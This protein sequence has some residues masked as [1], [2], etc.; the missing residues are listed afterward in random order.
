MSREKRYNR[1]SWMLAAFVCVQAAVFLSGCGNKAPKEDTLHLGVMYSSDI[2]PL[3]MMKEKGMDSKYGFRLDMQVFS[4]AKDRDAAL[5][6]GKLDGV[7]TD[8]IGV[9]MYQNANLDVKITGSTDGDYV[10][11][12]GLGTGITSLEDAKG[13]SIAVSENTLIEYSLDYI[14]E[15]KGFTDAYLDKQVVPRIPDRLEMIR[16][17]KID[18]GLL[19]EPFSILAAQSG[20]L[21]LGSANEAG[22]Y[23]AVSAFTQKSIEKKSDMIKKFY[24]AYDEAVDY[25]NTT[26]LEEYEAAVIKGAGYPEELAGSIQLPVYRKNALPD[27]EDLEAAIAWAVKKRLCGAG[28]KPDALL[29]KLQ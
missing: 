27:T 24:Q 25:I 23:P 28:L 7:F 13:H 29:G 10:L 21:T 19:P 2:V 17:G 15:A 6:A 9:C 5:Q 4:S 26:P 12:A 8:Y 18:L 16:N 22:L 20:A 11:L 3:V 1:K 14:L